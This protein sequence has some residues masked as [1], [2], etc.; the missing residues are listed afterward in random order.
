MT[1]KR[2]LISTGIKS[3][4]CVLATY[5]FIRPG[6]CLFGP[7]TLLLNDVRKS[8]CIGRVK[9]SQLSR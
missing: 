8:R 6:A 4:G 3:P 2:V 9:S 7:D 5:A 1:R